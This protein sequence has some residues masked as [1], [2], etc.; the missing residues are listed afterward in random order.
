MTHTLEEIGSPTYSLGYHG[1]AVN[2]EWDTD[3]PAD[4]DEEVDGHNCA[5]GEECCGWNGRLAAPFGFALVAT[6]NGYGAE[7]ETVRWF[8]PFTV[9]GRWV[10]CEDCANAIADGDLSVT[11]DGV[12]TWK[13][14]V[15]TFE[16]PVS[17]PDEVEVE[18]IAFPEADQ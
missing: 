6:E 8:T 10:V 14:E 1:E 15:L 4:F 9:D 17:C 5:V 2:F 18:V 3:L 13:Q 11:P 7:I 12:W 16:T